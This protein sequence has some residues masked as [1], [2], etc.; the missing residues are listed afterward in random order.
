[1]NRKSTDRA[2]AAGYTPE[3]IADARAR[4]RGAIE[5]VVRDDPPLSRARR[6][7]ATT[8]VEREWN[9]TVL[10]AYSDQS[11]DVR[12]EALARLLIGEDPE[13]KRK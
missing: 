13:R 8:E 1:M 12:A 10:E 11:E 2:L 3:Q 5:D 7:G 4:L 6:G 9:K